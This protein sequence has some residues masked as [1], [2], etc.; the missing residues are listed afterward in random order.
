MIKNCYIG[1]HDGR[2][3]YRRSLLPSKEN[4]QYLKNM[5]FLHFF[6]LCWSVLPSWIRIHILTEDPDPADKSI[7]DPCGSWSLTPVARKTAQGTWKEIWGE[8][9]TAASAATAALR[10]PTHRSWTRKRINISIRHNCAKPLGKMTVADPAI[11]LDNILIP[12]LKTDQ[13]ESYLKTSLPLP[14]KDAK[15]LPVVQK[16]SSRDKNST[17]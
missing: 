6:L 15:P 5:K 16:N 17:G 1:L 10:T 8:L 12:Q 9:R 14:K 11:I 2:P 13:L 7:T 3:S 4:I